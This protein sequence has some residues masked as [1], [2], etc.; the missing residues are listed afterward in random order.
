MSN[1]PP[2][3]HDLYL[4][5]SRNQRITGLVLLGTGL[6]SS[7]IAVLLATSNNTNYNSNNGSTAVALFIIGAATG[8][9]SIPFMVLAHVNKNKAKVEVTGQ[10]TGFGLPR[11]IGKE[12]TGITLSIPIGK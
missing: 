12:I 2:K 3:D 6:V 11:N 4:Q 1:Q 5:R 7:G 10:K 9:A 8:I